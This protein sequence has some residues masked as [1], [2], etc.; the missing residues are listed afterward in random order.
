M[1]LVNEERRAKKKLMKDLGLKT[2]KQ[3]RKL[4]K[5]ERRIEKRR[6]NESVD[7]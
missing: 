7:K 5:E 3:Y 4:I 1:Q 6:K 2:G